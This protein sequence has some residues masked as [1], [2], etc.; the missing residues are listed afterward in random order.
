MKSRMK[1]SVGMTL[2]MGLTGVVLD[3]GQL[4]AQ[5]NYRN[6]YQSSAKP[7]KKPSLL[8][9]IFS[10]NKSK[11]QQT[12]RPQYQAGQPGQ[13]RQSYPANRSAGGKSTIQQM[14]EERY[15]AEG[16]EMPP[17]TMDQLSAQQG[18]Q[19][20][21]Q[22]Q[23]PY[24]MNN[25]QMNHAAQQQSY[26]PSASGQGYDSASHPQYQQTQPQQSSQMPAQYG[27]R[28]QSYSPPMPQSYADAASRRKPRKKRGFRGFLSRIN[29][30]KKKKSEPE[31][32]SQQ[33]GAG[34]YHVPQR[35]AQQQQP[36]QQPSRQ[37]RAPQYRAPQYRA[38]ARVIANTPPGNRDGASASN[39]RME[40][41]FNPAPPPA[42]TSQPRP[43]PGVPNIS[44]EQ[45]VER[46]NRFADADLQFDDE[47]PTL[48]DADE[49]TD[50]TAVDEA[51]TLPDK[52]PL[53]DF[54]D[55]E[56]PEESELAED[57]GFRP[58][59]QPEF[60][61]P[62]IRTPETQLADQGESSPFSGNT[63][64]D[65]EPNLPKLHQVPQRNTYINMEMLN[66]KTDTESLRREKRRLLLLSRPERKGLK[67]FCPVTL[68]NHRDLVDASSN[69]EVTYENKVYQLSSAEAKAE[70][71][72]APAE[73]APAKGGIDVVK[74]SLGSTEVEGT[75]EFAA[76]FRGRL[77]LFSSAVTY[78]AF[79]RSPAKYAA[80]LELP[81]D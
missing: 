35:F 38:P 60:Q 42:A 59:K 30:F 11:S 29:P 28:P 62:I 9:R 34:N 22:S 31:M 19:Q 63:L 53:P 21:Q 66:A 39:H 7:K 64:D 41:S 26:Q 70:F 25:A 72:R 12:A 15:R 67:G 55:I 45:P 57:E 32:Q 3:A 80:S 18:I 24:Q 48:A 56:L 20:P 46:P 2:L 44:S 58:T 74:Y 47:L 40:L 50:S 73:Y 5:T 10:R 77:Y 14:L 79:M 75:L 68:K 43:F 49:A 27:A 61:E 71:E 33:P 51:A 4:N 81:E 78:D 1:L 17:L 65:E 6:G 76:W 54:A 16:R 37:Y 36:S 8:R 23:Q 52:E 13:Y 69:F